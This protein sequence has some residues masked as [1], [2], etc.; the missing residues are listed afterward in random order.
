[1]SKVLVRNTE[2]DSEKKQILHPGV[3]FLAIT[4]ENKSLSTFY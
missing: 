3:D 2:V 1:M 4:C